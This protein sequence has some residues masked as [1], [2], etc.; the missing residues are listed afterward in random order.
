M[1]TECGLVTSSGTACIANIGLIDNPYFTG[2][3]YLIQPDKHGVAYLPMFNCAPYVIELQ[4]NKF[5]AVIENIKGCTYKE[6]NLAYINSLLQKHEA[7]KPKQPLIAAKRKL[8]EENRC[9]EVPAEYKQWYLQVLLQFHKAISED[10]FDL[11]RCRTDLHEITLKTEE[12]IFVKQFKILDAHMEEVEK[13]V[14]EWLKLG[15]IEPA[16]SKYN[17]PIFVVAKKN[18]GIRLV[19]DFRALNAETHIDKYCMQ[20][21]TEC[22]GEI[23]RSGSIIFSKLDLTAGFWQMLLETSS[24]PYTAFMVPGQGQ[25]QWV[26]S[27]MG[28]L[29][30][31]ASFQRMMEAVIEGLEGIIMYIDDLL[32]HSDMHEKQIDI[33]E[34]LFQQ[35][36]QNGI[37]VN[38]DKCVFGNKNVSYL[39]FRLTEKGIILG[40]DKLKAI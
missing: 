7:T 34:K 16:R 40:S 4:R 38:L 27:P 23:S 17:S 6:V 13:H 12:P 25:F 2:G 35:L 21:V 28:L 9:S 31:P 22:V 19:Q 8:I 3:L 14:I 20:D 26:T 36:V 33:L 24:R 1:N 5:I 15:V 32:V 37:K 10:R 30:C 11:G 29:V 18:G 39:G